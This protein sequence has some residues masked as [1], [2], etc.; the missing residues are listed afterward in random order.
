MT[1][2]KLALR[3]R[4]RQTVACL[5]PAPRPAANGGPVVSKA[6]RPAH[7]RRRQ[8]GLRGPGRT[9]ER[10]LARRYRWACRWHRAPSRDLPWPGGR[11]PARSMP[12]LHC[13]PATAPRLRERF[14]PFPHVPLRRP[15]E[16]RSASTARRRTRSANTDATR[17]VRPTH[18]PPNG[19]PDTRAAA[20]GGPLS[21]RLRCSFLRVWA[22]AEGPPTATATGLTPAFPFASFRSTAPP[23]ATS[24]ARPQRTAFVPLQCATGSHRRQAGNIDSR[25]ARPLRGA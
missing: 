7:R 6:F 8:K 4:R 20:D 21:L 16:D 14:I 11:T 2:R 9:R 25:S 5:P 10:A 22:C 19:D 3:A 12:P 1:G 23:P 24:Q 15:A 18:P 13:A 17:R